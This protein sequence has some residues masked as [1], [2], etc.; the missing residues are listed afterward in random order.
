MSAANMLVTKISREKIPDERFSHIGKKGV[1]GLLLNEKGKSRGPWVVQLEEHA[2]LEFKPHMG[3]R[4][5]LN[6]Q[7]LKKEKG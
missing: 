5:C 6:K 3:S 7:T 1:E 2:T 4:D